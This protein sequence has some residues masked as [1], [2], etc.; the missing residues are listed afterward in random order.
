M[1]GKI[2]LFGLDALVSMATA[3]QRRV[4]SESTT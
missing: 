4:E 3:G 2:N 1:R